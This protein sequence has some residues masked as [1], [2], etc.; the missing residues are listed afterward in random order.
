MTST[1]RDSSAIRRFLLENL[2]HNFDAL[3]LT[4]VVAIEYEVLSGRPGTRRR[5]PSANPRAGRTDRPARIPH[6]DQLDDGSQRVFAAAVGNRSRACRLQNVPATSSLAEYGPGQYEVNLA[7]APDALRVCDEAL[8]FKRIVKSIR[9]VH[10]VVKRPFFPSPIAT[11]RAADCTCTS[12][13][14]TSLAG[15]FLRAPIRLPACRCAM[16]LPGH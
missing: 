1:A 3:G 7:H 15:T 13:C 11:W 5:W 16:R 8:R 2:L 4:P 14:W 12:A 9:A 10:K 6:A